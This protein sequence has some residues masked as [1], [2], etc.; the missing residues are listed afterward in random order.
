MI[1]PQ[2]DLIMQMATL[3]VC[4]LSFSAKLYAETS[5]KEGNEG[6]SRFLYN[7]CIKVVKG[8]WQISQ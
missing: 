6:Q 5:R 3:A 8:E 1:V 4:L 7:K 2:A